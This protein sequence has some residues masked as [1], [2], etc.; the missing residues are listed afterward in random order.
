MANFLHFYR[1]DMMSGMCGEEGS[2]ML[3]FDTAMSLNINI[4][5]GMSLE[6]VREYLTLRC[7]TMITK[8]SPELCAHFVIKTYKIDE[9]GIDGEQRAIRVR[10]FMSKFVLAV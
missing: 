9:E 10:D 6:E 5:D 2:G 4:S 1:F 7:K 8:Y 3:V